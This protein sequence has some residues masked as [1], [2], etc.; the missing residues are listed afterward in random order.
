[1]GTE[2]TTDTEK[3]LAVAAV[4]WKLRNRNCL[5]IKTGVSFAEDS[6]FL[7]RVICHG[8]HFSEKNQ[9]PPLPCLVLLVLGTK[10]TPEKLPVG[11]YAKQRVFQTLLFT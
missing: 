8:H 9:E 5:R 2:S 1:M 6:G 10:R 7:N 4:C 11:S 3:E